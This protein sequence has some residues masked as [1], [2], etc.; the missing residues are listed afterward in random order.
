MKKFLILIL[1]CFVQNIFSQ[2]VI[3]NNDDP[4]Y[5]RAGI[6]IKPEFPGGDNEFYKFFNTN[7]KNPKECT[8]QCSFLVDFV[9]EKDGSLTNIKSL[10]E[11][12]YDINCEIIRVLNLSPKW[13]PGKH[14]GKTLRVLYSFVMSLK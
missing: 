5:N 9:V 11:L 13:I 14:D 10:R 8:K 1:I 6:D 12:D 2:D 3:S 7:F 4:I